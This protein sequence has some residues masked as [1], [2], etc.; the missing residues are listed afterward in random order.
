MTTNTS[1]ISVNLLA[2]NLKRPENF[3]GMHF[4][5][6][7]HMMPL[8]EV[9]RGEKTTDDTI[10]AVVAAT[11]KMGKTPIVVNDCPGFLVNRVLFPYFA[12]FSKLVLDGADCAS[13]VFTP[14]RREHGGPH[15][16]PQ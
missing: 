5:N 9:I 1:T 12:G 4:F 8:V 10:S 13:A 15:Q 2:K 11:L 16:Q 14:F 3:C 6:P 7:V